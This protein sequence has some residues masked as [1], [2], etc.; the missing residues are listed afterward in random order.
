MK[1]GKFSIGVMSP[2]SSNEHILASSFLDEAPSWAPNGRSI[3]FFRQQSGAKGRSGLYSVD[4]SGFLPERRAN[5]K[6]CF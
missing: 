5:T 4:I 6:R 3:I 1:S 2:D